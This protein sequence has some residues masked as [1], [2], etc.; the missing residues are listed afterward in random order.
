MK[1]FESYFIDHVKHVLSSAAVYKL[2]YID[3][4]QQL[5]P[6][7]KNEICRIPA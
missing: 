3:P 7:E 5:N 4:K 1:Y 6:W 2:K